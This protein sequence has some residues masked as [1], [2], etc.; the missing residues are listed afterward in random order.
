MFEA[1]NY[2]VQLDEMMDGIGAQLGKLTGAEWGI[3][4]TGCEAAIC[5]ATVACIAGTN[6][7][8]CQALPYIKVRD[9][10]IIPKHSRNPYDFGVRMTGAE[11]V[12]VDSEEALRSKISKRTAM[13]Y[14]LS[15]P[16]AERVL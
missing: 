14:I 15:G 3:A 13:I 9:Q 5:L 2:F 7:E 6:V 4:T 11:I 10:V 12:E 1:S 8:Q 16:A